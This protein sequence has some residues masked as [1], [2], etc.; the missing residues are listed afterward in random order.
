M[1][2]TLLD[3]G[4]ATFFDRTIANQV[5]R[6]SPFSVWGQT[7]SLDWLQVV[8]QAA[9]VALAILVAFVP[10]RRTLPQI[11]A[12]AAAV[13]IAAQITADHWFYLYIVWFLGPALIALLGDAEPPERS[14]PLSYVEQLGRLPAPAVAWR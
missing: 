5:D 9:A 12:L 4:L 7:P 8:V 10:R 14:Q 3:P 6:A 2:Q 1:L 11:A 13:M